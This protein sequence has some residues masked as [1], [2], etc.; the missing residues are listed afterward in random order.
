MWESGVSIRDGDGDGET[1]KDLES[2]WRQSWQVLDHGG[3]GPVV[4]EVIVREGQG[5]RPGLGQRW[6]WTGGVGDA[7][8]ALGGRVEA[9]VVSMPPRR[10]E[11]WFLRV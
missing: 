6:L 1:R 5:G 8:K 2:F 11:L 9:R 10:V 4:E 7:A 3:W